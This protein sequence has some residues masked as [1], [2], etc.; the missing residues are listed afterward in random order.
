M[1]LKN[2]TLRKKVY[3]FPI[4]ALTNYRKLSGTKQGKCVIL[5]FHSYEVQ[6]GSYWAKINSVGSCIFLPRC[7]R[8]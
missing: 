7:S 4:A 8:E 1:N 5:Q 6:D 3:W 2:I